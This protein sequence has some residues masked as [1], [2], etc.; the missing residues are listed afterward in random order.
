MLND[1]AKNMKSTMVKKNMTYVALAKNSGLS[2]RKLH[3]I[4]SG[5]QA[6]VKLS[7]AE[8]VAKGLGVSVVDLIKVHE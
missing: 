4:A 6:D 3:K 8:K 1:F 7:T 5:E 2:G